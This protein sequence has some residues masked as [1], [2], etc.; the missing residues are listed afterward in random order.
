MTKTTTIVVND[1]RMARPG[2]NYTGGCYSHTRIFREVEPD[3]WEVEHRITT[4][5]KYCPVYCQF[6]ECARCIGWRRGACTA[7]KET[8]TTEELNQI[9]ETADQTVGMSWEEVWEI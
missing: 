5:E 3:T 1:N 6:Q 9:L 7:E 2:Q 4:E 8:V